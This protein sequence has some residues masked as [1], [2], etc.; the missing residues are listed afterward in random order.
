MDPGHRGLLSTSGNPFPEGDM[1]RDRRHWWL[2]RLHSLTG[3]IPVGAFLLEHFYTNSAIH[4]GAAAYDEAV[5][6]LWD[7][8]RTPTAL[9][10]FEWGLIFLP[11]AFHG[12]YGV[13]IW[14][15]SRNNVSKYP[16]YRNWM[17]TLQ[18]W[19]GL[20]L[21][22]FLGYHLWHTWRVV[23]V[24][25]GHSIVGV[26]PISGQ[27]VTLAQ[28]LGEYFSSSGLLL[29][30]YAVGIFAA[31]FHLANGLWNMAVVWGITISERSQRAF[32]LV[33]MAL[34]AVLFV[35]GIGSLVAFQQLGA[36]TTA[37]IP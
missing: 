20:F 1:D 4:A 30:F 33:C 29:G 10:I 17:Y 25:W 5:G 18:R 19:T 35:W 13:A 36:V 27:T 6:G 31:T 28:Y 2:R 3:L 11:L 32:G 7:L 8:F 37:M 12:G 16:T 26:S 14:W 24:E 9:T 21:V 23:N 15:T 22:V 34:F